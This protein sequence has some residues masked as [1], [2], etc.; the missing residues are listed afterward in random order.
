MV[1]SAVKACMD[2]FPGLVCTG[3]DGALRSHGNRRLARLARA[4]SPKAHRGTHGLRHPAAP[5]CA[6]GAAFFGAR[7]IGAGLFLTVALCLAIIWTIREFLP[8]RALAAWLLAPY[9]LWA[10]FAMALN[11]SIWRLNP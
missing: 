6:V 9:V 3:V 4:L 1:R 11:L 8:V 10:G 2:S 5:Q 7:N